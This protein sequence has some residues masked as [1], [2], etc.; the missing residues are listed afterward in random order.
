V[1]QR[2]PRVFPS[3]V[4][5]QEAIDHFVAAHNVTPR[6][7]S[8]KPILTLSSPPPLRECIQD[9]ARGRGDTGDDGHKSAKRH[10]NAEQHECAQSGFVG[11]Q[12]GREPPYGRGGKDTQQKSNQ[13]LQIRTLRILEG[14]NGDPS[15]RRQEDEDEDK[16]EHIGAFDKLRE[17]YAKPS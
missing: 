8:G 6:G 2:T 12:G 4:A 13:A 5:T 11:N 16:V 1:G 14:A 17:A 7:P 9:M 3:V 10:N 15:R